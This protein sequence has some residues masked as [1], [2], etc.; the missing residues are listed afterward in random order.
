[1]KYL[2]LSSAL[3]AAALAVG[4]GSSDDG[5][6]NTQTDSGTADTS[7]ADSGGGSDTGGG[8]DTGGMTDGGSMPPPP[9]LGAQIDRMGRPG[10]NTATNHT[11][12]GNDTTKGAAKDAYNKAKPSDG[13]TFV[14]EIEK[15]LAILDALDA[16][17][18]NQLFADMSKTDAS[19][20]ATLAT[21]LADDRLWVNTAATTCTTYLA[22]EANATMLVPNMDC[23]GR[24]PSYDVMK[25]TYSAVAAGALS[26]VT[27]GVPVPDRAKVM[28]FPYLAA[29]H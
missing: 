13:S 3:F 8:T 22:V 16:N 17:C 20:Y 28:T 4:C 1:M 26:G 19:R 21:V 18:G 15:N 29:A 25:I 23:G 12:D 6:S 24:M 9:T 2:V 10:I 5:G 7:T 11:F 27:D 14:A